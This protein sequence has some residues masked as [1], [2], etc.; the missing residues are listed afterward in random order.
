MSLA[1]FDESDQDLLMELV[2]SAYGGAL[3]RYAQAFVASYEAQLR[4]PSTDLMG[5]VR[6]EATSARIDALERFFSQLRDD[7]NGYARKQE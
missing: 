6:K 5:L 2:A 1:K 7:V 4:S 3:K